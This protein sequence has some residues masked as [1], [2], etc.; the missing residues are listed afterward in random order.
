[1][2]TEN[3]GIGRKTLASIGKHRNRCGKP[4]KVGGGHV[5]RVGGVTVCDSIL[6]LRPSSRRPYKVE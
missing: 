1:M 4:Q 5:T 6:L 2:V 3:V